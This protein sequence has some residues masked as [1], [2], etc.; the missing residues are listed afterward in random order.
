MFDF[1]IVGS[2]LFGSVCAYEL[3]KKG[4]KVL[5]VEKRNHVGG[6]IYTERIE[7]IDVHKYGAHIFH[8]SD[9][10]IWNY[11]NQFSKFNNFINSPIAKTN[12]ILYNLPFNM[13]TFVRL[14]PNVKTPEEARLRIEEEKRLAGIDNPKNL[15]EQAIM[16][17]GKTIYNTLIKSYTEKQWGKSCNQLPAFIIKRLPIRYTFDNNYFNDLYQ[18]IPFD[19]YTGIIK[20]M[21]SGIEVR[22]NYDY[23]EHKEE[24]EKNASRIIF[25]GPIDKYFDYKYGRL[26]YRSLRFETSVLN[27]KNF[28]GVAVVNYID[29][30]V[31]YTRIIEHKHFLF[32]TTS[33]KSIITKEYPVAYDGLNEPFYPINDN[34]NNVLFQ[35]YQNEAK[36]YPNVFFGGRLGQYKYMDMDDTIIE[37]IKLVRSF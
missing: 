24:L 31:P 32:D 34:K 11:I 29:G 17:V 6:N 35:K 36:L 3:F 30:E 26:E 12:N 25:T 15:E 19:G 33:S 16:L 8:T 22:L 14:W 18:G 7:N 13:N 2:G 27:T 4:Y 21:L 37:A 20:R 10:K 28:Q 1:I 23:F 5:V 9:A